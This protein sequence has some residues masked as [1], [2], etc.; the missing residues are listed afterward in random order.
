MAATFKCQE[1]GKKFNTPREECSR[2]GS[3]D[4][5]INS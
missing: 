5:D 3:S 2:C 1:C 4:I